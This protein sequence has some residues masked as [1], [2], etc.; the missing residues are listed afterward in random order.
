MPGASVSGRF[1]GALDGYV[2]VLNQLLHAR[3]EAGGPLSS[4]KESEFMSR[5]ESLWQAL[6]PAEQG[7]AYKHGPI[8]PK[9]RGARLHHA[10]DVAPPR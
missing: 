2:R 4:T 7:E 9:G 1:Y 10:P 8:A 6:D 3:L 5:L